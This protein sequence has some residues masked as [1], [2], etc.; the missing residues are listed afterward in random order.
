MDPVVQDEL[1]NQESS[2]QLLYF[3]DEVESY[4][5]TLFKELNPFTE[6][7]DFNDE[8]LEEQITNMNLVFDSDS[9]QKQAISSIVKDDIVA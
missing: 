6:K 5:K 4:Q 3:E 8:K 7:F 1:F 9:K 2:K